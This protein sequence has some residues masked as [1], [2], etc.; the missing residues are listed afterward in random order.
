MALTV[1]RLVT[2][3]FRTSIPVGWTA[4]VVA[5]TTGKNELQVPVVISVVP[6][7]TIEPRDATLLTDR[8]E[9]SR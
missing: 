7:F 4:L 8:V 6:H 2:F 9:S 5:A 3:V 1:R